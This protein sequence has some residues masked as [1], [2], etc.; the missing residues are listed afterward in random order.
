MNFENN[1]FINSTL[2]RQAGFE[3]IWVGGDNSWLGATV[4]SVIPK[5][6]FDS[7][8]IAYYRDE[9]SIVRPRVP[10]SRGFQ[11]QDPPFTQFDSRVCITLYLSSNA[12][13]GS[14]S[15]NM[16]LGWP[17]ICSCLCPY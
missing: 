3:H 5:G 12:G 10:N 6:L 8:G 13:F 7:N 16:V 14:C 4:P 1:I 2:K 11:R 17:N 9:Y 15:Q